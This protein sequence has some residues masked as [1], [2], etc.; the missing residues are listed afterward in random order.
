MRSGQH[1]H[2]ALGRS[3]LP[4]E[5]E[6]LLTDLGHAANEAAAALLTAAAGEHAADYR[7]HQRQFGCG[8]QAGPT[9]LHVYQQLAGAAAAHAD[10]LTVLYTRV[11]LQYAVQADAAIAFRSRPRQGNVAALKPVPTVEQFLTDPT[12]YLTD[13]RDASSPQDQLPRAAYQAV[14]DAV[15]QYRTGRDRL[16]GYDD[17]EAK[18]VEEPPSDPDA[19]GN[20]FTE[21]GAVYDIERPTDLAVALHAY[22]ADLIHLVRAPG[23]GLHGV[24]APM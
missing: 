24:R 1:W 13:I 16:D 23:E 5:L 14:L 11:A 10:R 17:P 12:A 3:T 9:E 20:L 21:P 8:V 2:E 15:E 4:A 22:A 19:P 7:L 6:R 18:H